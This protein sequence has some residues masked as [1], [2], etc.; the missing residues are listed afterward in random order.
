MFVTGFS[1]SPIV[2]PVSKPTTNATARPALNTATQGTPIMTTTKHVWNDAS[3]L[4]ELAGKSLGNATFSLNTGN[5]QDTA[6]NLRATLSYVERLIQASAATGIAGNG[7]DE[8]SGYDINNPY[9]E[10]AA[11]VGNA[12]QTADE[13]ENYDINDL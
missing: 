7:A 6:N 5:M 3:I 10:K 1:S 12:G 13:F 8:F 2:Q 11:A 4:R 9:G